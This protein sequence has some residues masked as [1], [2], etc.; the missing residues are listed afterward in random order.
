MRR[1]MLNMSRMRHIQLTTSPSPEPACFPNFQLDS[2]ANYKTVFFFST[3]PSKRS[4]TRLFTYI[5]KSFR[6]INFHANILLRE[7]VTWSE[8]KIECKRQTEAREIWLRGEIFV[9]LKFSSRKA[10]HLVAAL[11]RNFVR[12]KFVA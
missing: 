2:D 4:A 6:F 8:R 12:E 5:K 3:F 7:P 11:A 9:S 10:P 1:S